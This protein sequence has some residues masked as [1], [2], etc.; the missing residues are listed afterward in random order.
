MVKKVYFEDIEPGFRLPKLVKHPTTRQLVMWAGASE[1]FT[2]LHYDKDYTTKLGLP[3]LIVHGQLTA[4]IL[5]QLITDWMGELG[6]FKKLTVRFQNMFLV[7]NDIIC[8]GE[9]KKIY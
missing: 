8:Q 1:D 3:N 5:V 6:T 7:N 2:E 4:A 9:V